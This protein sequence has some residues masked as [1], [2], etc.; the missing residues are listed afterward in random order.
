MS[1]LPHA[2]HLVT[3]SFRPNTDTRLRWASQE[4]SLT[5]RVELLEEEASKLALLLEMTR[6][7]S[8]ERELDAVMKLIADHTSRI[9]HCDRTSVFLLD[10]EKDELYALI[11]Q[12]LDVK[13]LRF[14]AGRGIA[15]AVAKSGLGLNVID[16]YLDP[17]FNPQVDKDTGYR[18]QSILC[19]P[20]LDQ[21]GRVLGVIQCLN[22]KD[23]LSGVASFDE[24]DEMVLSAVAA[25]ASVYLDNSA[26]RRRMDLL[27]EAFV[28]ATSRSI[29]DRDPCTSGHSRRVMLYSLNLARAV[30]E[31]REA[32]F[33]QIAYTRARILQLRYACLL[34]DVGKIGVREYILCKASKL[35]PPHMDSV[36]A[37]LDLLRERSRSYG[38][39]LAAKDR[40]ASDAYF[41]HTHEPLCHELDT[42]WT[43]IARA[44]VSGFMPEADVAALAEY[45]DKH[46]ITGDEFKNLSIRRGNLTEEEWDDMRSHVTKSYRMLV[47]IPWP[48][49]LKDLPEVAYTHHEKWD[50]S[51]YPRKLKADEIHFDGQIMCVADIYDALTAS[52]RPYKKAIPHEKARQILMQEEAEKGRLLPALVKLFFDKE[53]Y[54]IDKVTPRSGEYAAV[55]MPKKS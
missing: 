22:K 24:K 26:L 33:D 28:D 2:E 17:R 8:S 19:M 36:R 48:P 7:L 52:D 51:G 49:E 6:S 39:E 23:P 55:A 47:Q 9:M 53:C 14:S 4:Q 21:K 15:G 35:T 45:R 50:G 37:R 43:A 18:T 27:F 41:K 29:D 16:A 5:E 54:H 46:W 42:A 25:Q 31:C 20:L 13:E 1:E 10:T 34:H 38:L 40:A 32:P 11:A 12:G 3:K 44:N 30:N